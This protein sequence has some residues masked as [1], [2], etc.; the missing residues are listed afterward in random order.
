[1]ERHPMGSSWKATKFF[2]SA[3]ARL[4]AGRH[5]DF[6]L[7]P[8]HRTFMRN[9]ESVPAAMGS[10]FRPAHQHINLSLL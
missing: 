2:C 8:M 6:F 3:F 7:S 4:A 5:G 9:D 10:L 1:M